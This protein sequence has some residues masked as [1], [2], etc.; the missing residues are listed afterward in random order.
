MILIDIPIRI[1]AS[2]QG[3]AVS[4]WASFSAT[5]S[6]PWNGDGGFVAA[7]LH[8]APSTSHLTFRLARLIWTTAL[9]YANPFRTR[10][11]DPDLL[12]FGGML[13]SSNIPCDRGR[14]S[15]LSCGA[16]WY[17]PLN[18]DRL[19]ALTCPSVFLPTTFSRPR[20]TP[21]TWSVAF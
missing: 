10:R 8:R 9:L 16:P 11:L 13:G 19:H 18:V 7:L 21:G 15:R 5:P 2:R 3:C 12:P 17:R 1:G 20:G 4:P 14:I 6:P